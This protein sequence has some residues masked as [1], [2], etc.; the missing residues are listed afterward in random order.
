[1][2]RRPRRSLK[3]DHHSGKMAI[4]SMYTATLMLVISSLVSNA[5]EMSCSTGMTIALP[6][7]P[8][9]AQNAMINVN[10]HFVFRE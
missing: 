10:S 4:L 2:V 7:G 6:I 9:M 5:M 8:A 3:L 1:M